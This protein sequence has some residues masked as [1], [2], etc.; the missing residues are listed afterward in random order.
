MIILG[1]LESDYVQFL[2]TIYQPTIPKNREDR[3]AC[4]KN[5]LNDYT[6]ATSRIPVSFFAV[7]A[8][9]SF[10]AAIHHLSE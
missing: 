9:A 2:H 8:A 5:K 6:I 7:F 1:S 10:A 3:L 4:N